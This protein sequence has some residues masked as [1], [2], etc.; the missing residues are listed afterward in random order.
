MH[1]SNSVFRFLLLCMFLSFACN[2]QNTKSTNDAGIPDA[3]SNKDVAQDASCNLG[4]ASNFP[5]F[6]HHSVEVRPEG[7]LVD[8]QWITL[9]GGTVQW[10]RIPKGEWQ[11]RLRKFAAAFNT[12]DVYVPLCIFVRVLTSATK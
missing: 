11:D 2:Q 6:S 10:F 1:C 3:D 12:V 7:F 4:D 9:R 8:G 5:V